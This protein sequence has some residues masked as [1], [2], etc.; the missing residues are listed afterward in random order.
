MTPQMI[1]LTARVEVEIGRKVTVRDI[2][3]GR[4][5][6]GRVRA[7]YIAGKPPGSEVGGHLWADVEDS[8]GRIYRVRAEAVMATTQAACYCTS[9]A[10][11]RCDFCAGLRWAL[12]LPVTD[13]EEDGSE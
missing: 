3:S 9:L 7:A 4:M 5:V 1:R 8:A 13:D 11:G 6:T 12:A 2:N 10:R